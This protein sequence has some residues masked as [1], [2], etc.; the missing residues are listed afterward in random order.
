MKSFEWSKSKCL[1]VYKNVFF[2]KG[3]KRGILTDLQRETY[4][5]V[6]NSLIDFI[7]KYDGK[8]KE[9]MFKHKNHFEITQIKRYIEFLELK[10]LIFWCE[11]SEIKFFN[12]ID[13][14]WDNPNII[15]NAI[16][17]IDKF[18]NYSLVKVF[19][20]LKGVCCS[21]VQIRA[22]SPFDLYFFRNLLSY[23]LNTFIR[24]IEIITPDW[25][26]FSVNESKTLVK[27][28]PTLSTIILHSSNENIEIL[29]A[30]FFNFAIF[31]IRDKISD[32][33]H[34]GNI[35]H[36]YFTVNFKSYF[37]SLKFNSC[38][39][40]KIGI[41]KEGFIKQCPSMARKFGHINNTNFNVVLENDEF[42]KV[43]QINK[44]KIEDC[45]ICEFRNICT[46]CRAYIKDSNNQF[47]KPIKCNYNPYEAVWM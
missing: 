47:S 5:L 28:F 24:S 31:K 44:S 10:D 6:P 42:S 17:D 40:R 26:S 36:N 27:E 35:S 22:F 45:N 19:E 1:Q 46:D 2:T 7:I 43:W 9:W 8:T 29:D 3:I 16:I 33:S 32:E 11:R 13:E 30:E 4:Y 14:Y 21:H 12:N 18:S 20:E 15:T 39:N 34:C 37:E 41:D 38:L 23:T 25:I